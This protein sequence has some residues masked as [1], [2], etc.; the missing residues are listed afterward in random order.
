MNT[1]R[2]LLVAIAI[3]LTWAGTASAYQLESNWACGDYIHWGNDQ[4]FY[5]SETSFDTT[6]KRDA[7]RIPGNR[8]SAVGDQSFDYSWGT[9]STVL[10]PNERNEIWAATGTGSYASTYV[11]SIGCAIQEAD[12]IFNSNTTWALGV[13]ADQGE[14]YWTAGAWTPSSTARYMR[15]TA[16]HELMH[17]A[18]L[19]HEPQDYAFMNYGS[20]PWSNRS[21]D[22]QIEPLPDDRQGLRAL[23]GNSGSE[24]DAAVLDTWVDSLGSSATGPADQYAICKV[25][26]GSGWSGSTFDDYC[27]ADPKTTLYEGETVYA[28]FAIANYGTGALDFDIR[29]YFSTDES[30]SS[31]DVA[32]SQVRSASVSANSS[33][34][35]GNTFTVPVGLTPG[36]EYYAIVKIEN[37]NGETEESTQNNWIPLRGKIEI[38]Q[39]DLAIYEVEVRSTYTDTYATFAGRLRA[40]RRFSHYVWVENLSDSATS[41]AVSLQLSNAP[42]TSGGAATVQSST[43]VPALA[44][45]QVAVSIFTVDIPRSSGRTVETRTLTYTLD[46]A[47]V[48]DD[49]DRAN[50]TAVVTVDTAFFRPDYTVAIEDVVVTSLAL[51]TEGEVT[52]LLSN[53]GMSAGS[54]SSVLRLSVDGAAE[55]EI[56]YAALDYLSEATTRL[57][58]RLTNFPMLPGSG[59]GSAT[60]HLEVCAD[61]NNVIAEKDETNNCDE[62]TYFDG[63]TTF[64]NRL[65][66][67]IDTE[68]NAVIEDLKRWAEL[69]AIIEE[70]LTYLFVEEMPVD[71]D[72]S[73]WVV[74]G[75]R[76]YLGPTQTFVDFLQGPIVNELVESY[77]AGQL[78]KSLFIDLLRANL[79][80]A[81]IVAVWR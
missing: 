55:D 64:D 14:D 34:R 42:A 26:G 70:S 5:L 73:D 62:Y 45:G 28:R 13:P 71:F 2:C 19:E 53:T 40:V 6:E 44:P 16:I 69:N 80:S 35:S 74:C 77:A 39:T 61:V 38:A 56:N 60:L 12:I 4:T 58:F 54:S 43:S 20:R 79:I 75:D 37:T 9:A 72:W 32:A 48:A 30:L 23:Y 59:S 11:W 25:A 52:V 22:D 18:G 46:P 31:S 47:A 1:R 3:L 65:T 49:P 10:L 29:L 76:T 78:D 36:Q 24:V 68:T 15:P 21:A 63:I 50:N 17:A 81:D 51:A 8:I 41:P 33:F 7:V 27:A 57:Q 67:V 66:S